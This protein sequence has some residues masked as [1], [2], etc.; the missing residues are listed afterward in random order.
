[1]TKQ[2]GLVPLARLGIAAGLAAAFLFGGTAIATAQEK[3]ARLSYHWAPAHHSAIFTNKF[4]DEINKRA[5]GKLKIDVFPSAQLYGIQQTL[6][7]VSSGAIEL[8]GV[9][10]IVAFPPLDRSYD[11][12]NFPGYWNGFEHMRGFFETTPEGQKLWESILKKANAVNVGYVPVGP[13]VM[14]STKSPM[15]SVD[16]I[17]GLKARALAANERPR[18]T[19][20]GAS[21]VAMPT[22]EI[23]TALQNGMID[24]LNTV[25]SAIKAYSWW[26]YIKYAQVPFVSYADAN[27]IANARWFNGLAPDVQKIILEVGAQITK[28]ST[29]SIVK[30]SME[31]LEEFKKRGGK[32]TQLAADQQKAFARVDDEKVIPE[33]AK[34]VAP[35][36]LAAAR[37]Y[38]GR[39]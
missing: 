27:I 34:G 33:M 12:V 2:T 28:E 14:F 32:V 16:S 39:Q 25:P 21:V 8:G 29:D 20:L 11:I 30:S 6:G 19:A 24:T 9:V 7:A 38:I 23:Y 26:E 4:A 13:Y 1:M 31:T 36:V 10:S 17:K 22:E 3:V 5:K 35:D 18:W 15:D 37:K